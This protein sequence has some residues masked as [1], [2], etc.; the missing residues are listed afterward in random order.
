MNI[1]PHI[2]Y[3][4]IIY[5]TIFMVITSLCKRWIILALLLCLPTAIEYV[6]AYLRS[7]QFD[8]SNIPFNIIGSIIGILIVTFILRK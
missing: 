5:G 6:Q 7:V 4:L 2:I 1:D 3:H 8:Y